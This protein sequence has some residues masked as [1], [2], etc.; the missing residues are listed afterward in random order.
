MQ[1]S[2]CIIG[3]FCLITKL[4]VTF[5]LKV[6]EDYETLLFNCNV[7]KMLILCY[8]TL[9]NRRILSHIQVAF[10]SI[11]RKRKILFHQGNV[12]NNNCLLNVL[13][14]II[15]LYVTTHCLRVKL[16]VIRELYVI[17]HCIIHAMSLTSELYAITHYIIRA[18]SL[19]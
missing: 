2:D 8:S 6:T 19:K 4:Y 11:S 17:T 16:T 5:L 14:L 10:N 9:H 15:K 3:A 1:I 18:L 7:N 12:C 13:S